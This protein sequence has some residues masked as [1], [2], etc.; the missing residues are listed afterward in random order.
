MPGLSFLLVVF[1]PMFVASV[2]CF[3]FIRRRWL[4]MVVVSLLGIAGLVPLGAAVWGVA[5]TSGHGSDHGLSVEEF[6]HTILRAWPVLVICALCIA[7]PHRRRLPL[8]S[9]LDRPAP[10]SPRRKTLRESSQDPSSE[11]APW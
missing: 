1:L 3:C 5:M 7:W 2:L 9:P 10:I 4:R 8:R 6:E 11:Q